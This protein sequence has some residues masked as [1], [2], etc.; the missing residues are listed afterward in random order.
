LI[1]AEGNAVVGNNVDASS[2]VISTIH[3]TSF[4]GHII[5]KVLVEM[6]RSPCFAV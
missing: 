5:A 1:E 4:V 2:T 3:W 6:F